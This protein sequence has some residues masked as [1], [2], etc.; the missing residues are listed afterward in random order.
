MRALPS[1]IV[2][3]DNWCIDKSL[4]I[5]TRIV[6]MLQVDDVRIRVIHPAKDYSAMMAMS[7]TTVPI[8]EEVI[9]IDVICNVIINLSVAHRE[10]FSVPIA[11]FYWR[12]KPTFGAI[13]NSIIPITNFIVLITRVNGNLRPSNWCNERINVLILSTAIKQ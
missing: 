5:I 9:S 7:V 4:L 3:D 11:V 12:E 2:L 1:M 10:Y 8:V 6:Y 13:S